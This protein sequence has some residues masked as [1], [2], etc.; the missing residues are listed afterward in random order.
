[1]LSCVVS[2]VCPG[3][4]E[5]V[6]LCLRLY[7]CCLLPP[8]GFRVFFD[9]VELGLAAGLASDWVSEAV[10]FIMKI[11]L[12]WSRDCRNGNNNNCTPNLKQIACSPKNHQTG[13]KLF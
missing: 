2:G 5:V 4:G 9:A 6:D 3:N 1:M 12:V 10:G 11:G 8:C 13:S 7:L